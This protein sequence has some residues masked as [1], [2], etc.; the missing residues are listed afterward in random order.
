MIYDFNKLTL[1]LGGV[2]S[3]ALVAIGFLLRFLI[4]RSH[5]KDMEALRASYSKELEE[6]RA[7]LQRQSIRFT[8]Y[9]EQQAEALGAL[10][11]QV[12]KFRTVTVAFINQAHVPEG[13]G[14]RFKEMISQ[15]EELVR[16]LE[17]KRIY[18]D[19]ATEEVLIQ[20]SQV[21]S[22]AGIPMIGGSHRAFHT[23]PAIRQT[24]MNNL[25]EARTAVNK[26]FY[27]A[28]TRLQAQFKA[29]LSGDNV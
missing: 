18:V 26:D 2:W 29:V 11:E 3:I 13:E 5:A 14:D 23:D 24:F 6:L 21:L 22:T 10:Y 27:A 19:D 12:L 16:L 15:E 17:R 28:L 25:D 8:K 1:V 20:A 7:N 9:N 4:E